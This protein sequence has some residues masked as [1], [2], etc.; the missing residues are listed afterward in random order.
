MINVFCSKCKNIKDSQLKCKIENGTVII[1]CL[2]CGDM[3][4]FKEAQKNDI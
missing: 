3:K 2:E 4:R 1:E